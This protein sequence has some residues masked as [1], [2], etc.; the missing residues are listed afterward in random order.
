MGKFRYIIRTMWLA[1]RSRCYLPLQDLR[2]PLYEDH[3]KGTF[4]SLNQP[5]LFNTSM[6]S[7]LLGPSSLATQTATLSPTAS[8]T[9][10]TSLW[11]NPGQRRMAWIPAHF[12]CLLLILDHYH[13]ELVVLRCFNNTPMLLHICNQGHER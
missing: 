12:N 8:V 10:S 7:L 3:F 11:V 9:S 4:Y 5:S 6:D 2:D 1:R 13:K